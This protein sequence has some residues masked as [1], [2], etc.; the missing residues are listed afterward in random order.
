MWFWIAI[1]VGAPVALVLTGLLF[2]VV[3]MRTGYRPALTAVRRFNRRF[4]NRHNMKTAGQPGAT[5]SVIRHRGRSSGKAYAT[6]IG[7][8]EA[9]DEFVILLPYGTNPDWLK[10]VLAAGSA[11]VVHEGVPYR[12]TDPEVV[13][14]ASVARHLSRPE[15]LARLLFGVDAALRLHVTAAA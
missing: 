10:N 2:L 1:A 14:A 15:R 6:P 13:S 11:E 3:A 5:S 8:T 9:G 12:A 7:V 4:T